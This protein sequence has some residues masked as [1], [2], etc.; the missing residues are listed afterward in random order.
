MTQK[1]HQKAPKA[2]K[3][4]PKAPKGTQTKTPKAPKGEPGSAF[5]T[6]GE[7]PTGVC[8]NPPQGMFNHTFVGGQRGDTNAPKPPQKVP[9]VTQIHYG[10][11][12][13]SL[14]ESTITD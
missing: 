10:R 8:L 14:Y 13:G 11:R 4:A 1:G 3:K 5:G 2:F 9:E 6:P 12:E 7:P